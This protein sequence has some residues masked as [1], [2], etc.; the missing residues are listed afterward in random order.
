VFSIIVED[1]GSENLARNLWVLI[2][3]NFTALSLFCSAPHKLDMFCCPLLH[4]LGLPQWE[5]RTPQLGVYAQQA[6]RHIGTL[7]AS[8][9]RAVLNSLQHGWRL[10]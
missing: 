6:V 1:W 2:Y 10:E 7:T 9:P 3:S 5:F 8:T 4:S